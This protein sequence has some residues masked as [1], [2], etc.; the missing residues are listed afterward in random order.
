MAHVVDA[1]SH[2]EH[3]YKLALDPGR[4]TDF[5]QFQGYVFERGDH[6]TLT[7]DGYKAVS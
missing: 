4:P 2:Q 1:A 3:V 7:H 5:G 6:L